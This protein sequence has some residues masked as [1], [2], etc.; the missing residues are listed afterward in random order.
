MD[1]FWDKKTDET[2]SLTV[3]SE[4]TGRELDIQFRFVDHVGEVK[5]QLTDEGLLVEAK[6]NEHFVKARASH[7][8]EA[9]NYGLE[10]KIC[11]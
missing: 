9:S 3:K 1:V 5:T 10:V 8:H 11:T 6:F 4:L 7:S 2:K